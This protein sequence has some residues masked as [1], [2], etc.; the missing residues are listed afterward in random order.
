VFGHVGGKEGLDLVGVGRHGRVR[1]RSKHDARFS[2]GGGVRA[3]LDGG[4]RPDEEKDGQKHAGQKG[5]ADE[6][7]L[8]LLVLLS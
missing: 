4:D 7:A 1:G 5:E 3:G 6:A 2:V 8:D